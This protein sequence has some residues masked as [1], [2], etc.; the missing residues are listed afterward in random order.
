MRYT[1]SQKYEIIRLV[2]DSPLSIRKTLKQLQVNR[3]TFYQWYLKYQEGGVE[4]LADDY[5]KP[6]R[7]WNEIPPVEK[8]QVVETALELPDKSPRELAWH[9]TDTRGYYIS[10]SS[11]YR[12]LKRHGLVTSPAYM[13]FTA[14]RKFHTPT[15]RINELWQTDFTYFRIVHWGWY[16][17]STVID[18]YSRYI[19]AWKL[20][21][22]M[23]A[24]DVKATLDEAVQFAGV[25]DVPVWHR[26]RLLSDNGPCYIAEALKQYVEAEGIRHIHGRA[27]HPMTQG[28]I[29]RYHR[30]LK[31]IVLLE[32]YYMPGE[33]QDAIG[34]FV[35]HYNHYRYHE[36]LNN[37]T[38]ADVYYGRYT[39]VL[40]KR[41]SIRERTMKERRRGFKKVYHV[42]SACEVVS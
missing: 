35:T 19:I 16:Y 11:V 42:E 32:H 14:A 37:V 18:D 4:G 40:Q 21:K 7:F 36:S 24:E 3:S 38:P 20:C 2:E 17:L 8:Q 22:S 29:E 27:F 39:Q 13:M 5:T 34:G 26:P 12:I 23:T 30:S 33:L 9:I 10:E 6:R 41:G 25:R 1:Q 28:K 31:N 15:E